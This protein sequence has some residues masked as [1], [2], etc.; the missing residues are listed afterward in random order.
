S[1]TVGVMIFNKPDH[2]GASSASSHSIARA[3]CWPCTPHTSIGLIIRK[4]DQRCRSRVLP[5]ADRTPSRVG[6]SWP[7]SLGKASRVCRQSAAKRVLFYLRVRGARRRPMWTTSSL[8]QNSEWIVVA[9]AAAALVIVAFLSLL[10]SSR[11]VSRLAKNVEELAR[12]VGELRG[13]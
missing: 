6:R 9:I 10:V 1:S 8:L 4:T 13:L 12:E 11:K 3:E 5:P 7:R 2:L